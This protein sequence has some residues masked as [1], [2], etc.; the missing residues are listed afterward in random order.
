MGYVL[1]N[2]HALWLASQALH[3]L[4]G[5]RPIIGHH[6]TTTTATVQVHRLLFSDTREKISKNFTKI[7]TIV[8]QQSKTFFLASLTL[9]FSLSLCVSLC[10]SVSLHHSC[11]SCSCWLSK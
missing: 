2:K 9:S 3:K 11:E 5:V 10:L 6:T 7:R 8:N 1:R 4:D